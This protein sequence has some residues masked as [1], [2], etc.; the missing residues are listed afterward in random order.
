MSKQ[1]RALNPA[2]YAALF[3]RLYQLET[4]G[5]SAFEAFAALAKSS[6]ELKNPLALIQRQLK[7]GRPISEAGYR[8]GIFDEMQKALIRAAEASGSLAAV[9]RNL[10]SYY[11]ALSTRTGRIRS[12]LWLPAVVLAIAL[13]IEPLPAL[14][15]AQIGL[16]GYLKLSLGRFALI[17]ALVLFLARLP[18]ILRGLG[19]GTVWDRLLLGM[20]LI[21]RRIKD[22]QLNGFFI[23]LAMLLEGGLA[24]AEA[25]PLAVKTIRNEALRAQFNPVLA[26]AGSGTSVT[27]TLGKVKIINATMLGMVDSSEHSG[28]LAGGILQYAQMEAEALRLQDDAWAAWLPRAAYALVAAWLAY[29]MLSGPSGVGVIP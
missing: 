2:Q 25:L 4:A 6:P 1:S 9:Y 11:T 13:F 22:R 26:M 29:S 14:V 17:I 19:L 21:A 20:P 15:G 28:R 10:A 7:S 16:A 12:G 24:F 18:G 23:I 27:D 8:A 5:L 3:T